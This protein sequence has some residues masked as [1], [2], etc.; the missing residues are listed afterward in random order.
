MCSKRIIPN[1]PNTWTVS[2]VDTAIL[3]IGSSILKTVM[4]SGNNYYYYYYYYYYYLLQL[5]FHSWQQSLH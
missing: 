4:K 5:G 3:L 1:V 2:G